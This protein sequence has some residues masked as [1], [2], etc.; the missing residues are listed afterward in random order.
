MS[1]KEP[2]IYT[3]KAPYDIKEELSEAYYYYS[4]G[5]YTNASI[6]EKLFHFT[7]Y[8]T[9][10]YLSFILT[11]F[12]YYFITS[13]WLIV[14]SGILITSILLLYGS[15]KFLDNGWFKVIEYWVKINQSEKLVT[16]IDRLSDN[17]NFYEIPFE[18]IDS[19]RW[20]G[21]PVN[22]RIEIIIGQLRI[23]TYPVGHHSDFS[24]T[25]LWEYLASTEAE[26]VNW[27]IKLFCQK[28][29][30]IYGHH[31]G[32]ATCPFDPNIILIEPNIKGRIDPEYFHSDDITRV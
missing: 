7:V 24:P 8:L 15:Y 1:Y 26:M 11:L 10:F 30:R 32:T 25:E 6:S 22:G 5:E 12:V 9:P 28:C 21:A 18:Q 29:H 4:K 27:P 19:I 23:F 13:H 2:N 16:L 20:H 14:Q 31:I 17:W 3:L